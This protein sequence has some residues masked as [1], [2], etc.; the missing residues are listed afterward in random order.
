MEH[1][2]SNAQTSIFMKKSRHTFVLVGFMGLNKL[3]RNGWYP[4]QAALGTVDR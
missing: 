3:N 2:Y 4:Q 1:H